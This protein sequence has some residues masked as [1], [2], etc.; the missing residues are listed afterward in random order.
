VT[1]NSIQLI[2]GIG[3]F[4]LGLVIGALMQ[5]STKGDGKKITRLQ[6]KLAESEDKY[7]RYQADVTSHFMDTARKVQTLNKSYREV[8]NQLA[9]GARKLCDD[10]DMEEFLSLNFEH[11]TEASVRGHAIE[12]TDEGLAPPMDYAP[13]EKPEEEGTLSESYGFEEPPLKEFDE[14]LETQYK[15]DKT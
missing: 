10:S 2:A 9:A 3:L 13:K 15:S 1:E 7:T 8:N 6:Q 4:L 11:P 5:R 12:L 14:K